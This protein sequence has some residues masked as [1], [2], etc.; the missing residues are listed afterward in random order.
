[1]TLT[2]KLVG[3]LVWIGV[4]D[5]TLV[6]WGNAQNVCAARDVEWNTRSHDN[7]VFS[8]AKPSERAALAAL[9][10]APLKRSIF[11]VSTQFVPQVSARRRAVFTSGV[12]AMIGTRGRSRAVNNA[13]V[14]L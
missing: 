11:P 7:L 2:P 9:T 13:V 3:G 4:K 1:M 8:V 5:Q 12:I 6:A 10:T 14:P